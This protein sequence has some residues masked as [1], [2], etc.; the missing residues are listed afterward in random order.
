MSDTV[1]LALIAAII[2]LVSPMI[3]AGV[4]FFAQRANKR[5]DWRRQDEV[6]NEFR[7]ATKVAEKANETL[8]SI[9]KVGELT[10]KIVNSQRTI[11]LRTVALS[12][13]ALSNAYPNDPL[14][15]KSAQDAENE[16]KENERS[17]REMA[18]RAKAELQTLTEAKQ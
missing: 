1:L 10:H 15:L 9:A 16:L 2:G 11:L 3:L 5:E 6:A 18:E 17:E 4:M 7:K 13:R 8:V 12:A 14:L